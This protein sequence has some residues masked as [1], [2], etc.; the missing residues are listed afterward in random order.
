MN[1]FK[2]YFNERKKEKYKTEVEQALHFLDKLKE[3]DNIRIEI[4]S[5]DLTYQIS[6]ETIYANGLEVMVPLYEVFNRREAKTLLNEIYYSFLTVEKDTP[7]YNY[8][9]SRVEHYLNLQKSKN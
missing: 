4:H 1:R 9:V 3:F 5:R 7:I 6:L 2:K 8:I